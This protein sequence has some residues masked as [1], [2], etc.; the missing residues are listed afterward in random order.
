MSWWPAARPVAGQRAADVAGAD[1]ADLQGMRGF[2]DVAR[3][4]AQ[5]ASDRSSG[6]QERAKRDFHVDLLSP[7]FDL[8]GRRTFNRFGRVSAGVPGSIKRGLSPF[9]RSGAARWRR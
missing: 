2:R 6:E 4:A 5:A 9:S 3:R 7:E 8:R 1:D